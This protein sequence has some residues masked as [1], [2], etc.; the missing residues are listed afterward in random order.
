MSVPAP[1]DPI[2]RPAMAARPTAPP[3]CCPA[4]TSP[5]SRPPSPSPLSRTAIA[6]APTAPQ[7]QPGPREQ[8]GARVLP[9]E[10]G[11]GI[12]REPSDPREHDGEGEGQRAV[13]PDAGGEQGSGGA[14][15]DDHDGDGDLAQPGRQR[16]HAERSEER[17]VGRAEYDQW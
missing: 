17:R 8:E 1:A 5:L 15:D 4:L 13:Q 7:A 2:A 3:S 10:R 11:R 6:M 14:A 9:R 16:A 12:E